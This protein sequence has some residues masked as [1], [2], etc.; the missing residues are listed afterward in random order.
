MPEM[1][2]SDFVALPT[3]ADLEMAAPWA[4]GGAVAGACGSLVRTWYE[5]ESMVFGPIDASVG[6]PPEVPGM[7]RTGPAE[8]SP[9]AVA[10]WAVVG[11]V[12]AGAF[13]ISLAA[14]TLQPVI[15]TA[16]VIAALFALAH[17]L[18]AVVH[19]PAGRI[20]VGE[21]P[22]EPDEDDETVVKPGT[23]AAVGAALVGLAF[24]AFELLRG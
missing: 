16:S 7:P 11:A 19:N 12:M 21:A 6:P 13:G 15:G 5:R 4:I 18:G 10:R 1:F 14:D 22:P 20:P 23:W 9:L 8:F 24:A 3:L 17:R 2:T